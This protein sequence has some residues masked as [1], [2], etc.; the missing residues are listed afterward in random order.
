MDAVKGVATPTSW[1][2]RF[3]KIMAQ[4]YA[5]WC[6]SRSPHFEVPLLND[7]L[8]QHWEI[9]TSDRVAMRDYTPFSVQMGIVAVAAAAV[10]ATE[11]PAEIL[12][13]DRIARTGEAIHS[14]ITAAFD[15]YHKAT[16]LS[17]ANLA[18]YK[19]L[20]PAQPSSSRGTESS[21]TGAA[22]DRSG[23]GR[24]GA[25]GRSGVSSG[26]Q[27][28]TDGRVHP[29]GGGRG[30]GG[31]GSS[32]SAGAIGGGSGTGPSGGGSSGSGQQWHSNNNQQGLNRQNGSDRLGWVSNN[33]SPSSTTAGNLP[34]AMNCNLPPNTPVYKQKKPG[35]RLFGRNLGI[36]YMV[37]GKIVL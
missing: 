32:G 34:R 22:G 21:V 15:R 5:M 3:A 1:A 13:S 7:L 11:D 30:A 16:V 33:P 10:A 14:H 37:Q 25:G 28:N 19:K 31:A 6:E 18:A 26:R 8:A 12:V 4:S 27:T 24:G 17:A 35:N 9:S 36:D 20:V 23:A 2:P 29:G